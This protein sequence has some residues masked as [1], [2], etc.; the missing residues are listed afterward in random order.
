[1]QR[2]R[3]LSLHT[4]GP[5]PSAEDLG[6]VGFESQRSH[7]GKLTREW[8][9]SVLFDTAF[10]GQRPQDAL[11]FLSDILQA[12]TEYSIIGQDLDGKI[13]L[14]N[15]ASPTVRLRASRSPGQLLIE[16]FSTPSTLS[17]PISRP[18][19]GRRRCATAS[20]K[21]C[22][23]GYART[24]SGSLARRIDASLR[25]CRCACRLSLDLEGSGR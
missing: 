18:R 20:G 8:E 7:K 17:P 15:G 12:S 9:G 14:W 21:D 2:D 6:S 10:V 16:H 5:R 24:A 23:P 4:R 11:A 13:L 19:C 3:S 22:S 25:S 1:M